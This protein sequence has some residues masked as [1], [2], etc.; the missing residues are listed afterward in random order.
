MMT[1][2]LAA[3][4]LLLV[5]HLLAADITSS[6]ALRPYGYKETLLQIQ[7]WRDANGG[8]KSENGG[9]TEIP[10]RSNSVAFRSL[11]TSLPTRAPP[12]PVVNRTKA[13]IIVSP[14]PPKV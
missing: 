8:K 11:R 3:I 13:F 4:A 14:P 6:S 9:D 12:P 1:R 2:K 5:L 10:G 7:N